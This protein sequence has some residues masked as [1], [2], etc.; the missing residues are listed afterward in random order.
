MMFHYYI[1][2]YL[3]RKALSNAAT[4]VHVYIIVISGTLLI[5]HVCQKAHTRQARIQEKGLEMTKKYLL[6]LMI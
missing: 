6:T 5:V 3:I 2:Y 1:H 4:H